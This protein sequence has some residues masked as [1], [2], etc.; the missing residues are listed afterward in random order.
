MAVGDVT[1]GAKASSEAAA[2]K[3]VETFAASIE[4]V[5][6]PRTPTKALLSEGRRLEGRVVRDLKELLRKSHFTRADLFVLRTALAMFDDASNELFEATSPSLPSRVTKARAKAEAMLSTTWNDLQYVAEEN[7]DEDLLRKV[8]D[9]RPGAS[10]DDTVADLSRTLPL[11]QKHLK[12]LKA[13]GSVEATR[14]V[15]EL[16]GF[17]RLLSKEQAEAAVQDSY[18]ELKER[19]DRFGLVLESHLARVRRHGKKAF[20]SKP[21]KASQYVD[22]Y[23]AQNRAKAPAPATTTATTTQ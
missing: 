23:Q 11:V 16:A 8:A 12:A 13:A 2:R 21:A 15:K 5:R 4:E 10:L 18:D 9:L 3:E 1:K 20:A 14:W 17:H 19:R 7:E 6:E 22:M